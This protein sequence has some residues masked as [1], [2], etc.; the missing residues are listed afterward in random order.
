MTR[1]EGLWKSSK[2]SNITPGKSKNSFNI[3]IL[4]KEAKLREEVTKSVNIKQKRG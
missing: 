2:R 3:Q 4:E 1:L